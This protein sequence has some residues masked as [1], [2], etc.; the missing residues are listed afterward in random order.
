[1]TMITPEMYAKFQEYLTEFPGFVIQQRN[2]RG[3]PQNNAGHIL[4]Y[5]NEVNP[6]QVKDSV[7]IYESGDYLGVTGLERQYEY[8]LR[9]KKGVEFVQRD[10]LGRIV[11]PW[12]N[13]VRDTIAVQGK[14]LMSSIDI[15]L[16]A[17]GEYM[18]TGKIGAIIAIEPETGEVL[19]W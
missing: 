15:E 17:L 1:M 4:G 3:Y 7:G 10:N 19:S 13:G 12:K 9:G 18:M 11:G 5:L 6:K 8:I 2:V 16:Q 14:D